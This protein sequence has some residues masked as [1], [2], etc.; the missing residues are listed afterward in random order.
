MRNLEVDPA[1]RG[2][3]L[4]RGRRHGDV[5]HEKCRANLT[6]CQCSWWIF[7]AFALSGVGVERSFSPRVRA[8]THPMTTSGSESSVAG[9]PAPHA[10]EVGHGEERVALDWRL[11]PELSRAAKRLRLE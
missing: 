2:P 5:R 6:R 10:G 9:G 3:Q 11:T 8:A 4:V 1:H 7:R